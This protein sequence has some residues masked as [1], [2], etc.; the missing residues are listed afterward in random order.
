MLALSQSHKRPSL[1]K[2]FSL[3][4][5]NVFWKNYDPI[6]VSEPSI[7]KHTFRSHKYSVMFSPLQFYIQLKHLS[8]LCK[9][10][11][12]KVD[13]KNTKLIVV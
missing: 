2:L 7:K 1:W 9:L 6:H 12:I 8:S 10:W 3:I 13:H 11:Y 5:V 4:V